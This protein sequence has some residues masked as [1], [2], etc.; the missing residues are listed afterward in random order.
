VNVLR[1]NITNR[2]RTLGSLPIGV[3]GRA[4]NTSGSSYGKKFAVRPA[5]HDDFAAVMAIDVNQMYQGRDY[6]QDCYHRFLDDPN[7]HA[8]VA[9]VDEQTAGFGVLHIFDEGE[10]AI[11]RAF[12]VHQDF[13]K[14]GLMN[15][16]LDDMDETLSE[17]QPPVKRVTHATT[18]DNALRYQKRYKQEGYAEIFRKRMLNY[19]YRGQDIPALSPSELE[20]TKSVRLLTSND[21]IHLFSNKTLVDRLFPNR[22]LFNTFVGFKTVQGNIKYLINSSAVMFMTSQS[23]PTSS[24]K[25]MEAI[26]TSNAQDQPMQSNEKA[27]PYMDMLSCG[28]LHMSEGVPVY[29]INIYNTPSNISSLNRHMLQ[30]I[31][32]LK[33]IIREVTSNNGML[34]VTFHDDIADKLIIDVLNKYGIHEEIPD[35]GSELV[36]FEQ[37]LGENIRESPILERLDSSVGILK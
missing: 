34:M 5:T 32:M 33:K 9:T 37:E 19:S 22:M 29:E 28:H 30:H 35:C 25:D 12:R 1:Q 14:L 36:W 16:M 27:I 3:H 17:M 26:Q 4:A 2:Y 15:M 7:M 6:L 8:V 20:S 31:H 23:I 11:K 24:S 21:V 13:Q 10:S 18:D